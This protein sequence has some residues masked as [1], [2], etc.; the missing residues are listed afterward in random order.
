LESVDCPTAWLPLDEHD[1]ELGYFLGYFI[2]A[3]QT[4]FPG[5][6]P[7]TQALINFTPLHPDATIAH[8]LGTRPKN[9]TNLDGL[10]AA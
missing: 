4:S 1:N 8:S 7:E 6:V 9:A 10:I 2:A 5:G 3:M